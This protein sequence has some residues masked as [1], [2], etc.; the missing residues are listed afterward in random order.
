[1]SLISYIIIIPLRL[2]YHKPRPNKEEYNDI[3]EKIISSSFPSHHSMKITMLFV[4]VSY[5]LKSMYLL[6]TLAFICALVSYTR[7]YLRKHYLADI[8]GGILIGLA[9]SLLLIFLI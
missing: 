7:Y 2:L 5:T 3:I 9:I 4:L 8:I 6:I 1:M